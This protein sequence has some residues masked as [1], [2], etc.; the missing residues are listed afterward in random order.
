MSSQAQFQQANERRVDR[1]RYRASVQ[2]RSGN[3]RAN[4]EVTDI[5]ELGA[6]VSGVFLVHEGDSFFI[7]I[8]ALEAI[9][10]KVAW[11]TDFEFGCEFLR[12]LSPVILDAITRS[13]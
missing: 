2:F 11:V 4:V 8:G 3:R 7:K 13:A 12:P 9:E 1:R 10:A 5:S 6:R